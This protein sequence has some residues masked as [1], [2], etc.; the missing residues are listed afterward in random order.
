MSEKDVYR[1][2]DF[3]LIKIENLPSTF[4]VQSMEERFFNENCIHRPKW[5][6]ISFLI[7]SCELLTREVT[8]LAL[9][10]VVCY[11]DWILILDNF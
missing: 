2:K 9:V 11:H 10:I 8:F 1:S 5:V 7:G 6:K 4:R 3:L